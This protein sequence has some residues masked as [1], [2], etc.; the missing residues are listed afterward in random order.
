MRSRLRETEVGREQR[1]AVTGGARHEDASEVERVED[2]RRLV[3]MARGGEEVDVEA[4]PV[5]DRLAAAQEFTELRERGFLGG[6]SAEVLGVDA[7]QSK[8]P[9][10]AQ[11]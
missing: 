6:G 2:L 1:Q 10:R 7:G 3:P 9:L 4:R 5:A 11:K 8:H